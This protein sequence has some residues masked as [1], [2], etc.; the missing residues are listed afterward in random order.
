MLKSVSREKLTTVQVFRGLAA[1]GVVLYHVQWIG[2]ERLGTTFAGNLWLEGRAGVDFFFVLSGFV[3]TYVHGAEL[4][5]ASYFRDYVCKRFIRIY[6]LLFVL[7]T[8]KLLA[9][10]LLPDLV[11]DHKLNLSLVLNSL[12]VLPQDRLP[13]LPPA[14]TLPH[15]VL[16]YSLF[17][18][19]IVLG[20]RA[21]RMM[22]VVW[23]CGILLMGSALW[24]AQDVQQI[25]LL[26]RFLLHPHNLEFLAG[27]TVASCARR[28][29][30]GTLAIVTLAIGSA[31]CGTIKILVY[32]DQQ[33][34]LASCLLWSG[35]FGS[36]LWASI[37]WERRSVRSI[38]HW[39]G[40]L[41]DASYSIYL[42]NTS[43]VVVG[44]VLA[45]RLISAT[46]WQLQLCYA[47][48]ALVSVLAGM[49]CYELIERPM[50]RSLRRRWLTGGQS[51]RGT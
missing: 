2:R 47:G 26:P 20:V 45:G 32:F 51:L 13:I 16:F 24:V 4:G 44:C 1:F 9:M 27:C 21:W 6:P 36:L 39:L 33:G 19:G 46:G 10:L 31:I 49:V 3:I 29:Q 34:S 12:M 25:D 11:A 48:I 41:G 7:T 40:Y 42:T 5:T 37:A 28:W 50:L 38:P 8:G 18:L 23:L 43:L 22:R 30:P 14:W 17:G 15:E 35:C